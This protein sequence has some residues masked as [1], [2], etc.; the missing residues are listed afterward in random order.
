MLHNPNYQR[1]TRYILIGSGV[2]LA[3]DLGAIIQANYSSVKP[4][5]HAL[6]I[7]LFFAHQFY[8]AL[9]VLFLKYRRCGLISAHGAHA[10]IFN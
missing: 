10:F 1:T 7:A 3:I 8:I 4:N 5:I 2:G 9:F 6:C